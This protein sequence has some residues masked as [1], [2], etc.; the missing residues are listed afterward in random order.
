MLRLDQ[1]I[2]HALDDP[3]AH[4]QR[5]TVVDAVLPGAGGQDVIHQ[6]DGNAVEDARDQVVRPWGACGVAVHAQPLQPRDFRR[7]GP[8]GVE[9]THVFRL[10]R[11]G[12]GAGGAAPPPH[13][14]RRTNGADERQNQQEHENDC[15]ESGQVVPDADDQGRT[16]AAQGDREQEAQEQ[17]AKIAVTAAHTGD[18]GG[19]AARQGVVVHVTHAALAVTRPPFRGR[20]WPGRAPRTS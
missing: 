15:E 4:D 20:R 2:G 3:T 9:Q 10:L 18:R 19:V 12:H 7:A 1:E 6:Q 17:Q 16:D 11:H 5:L 13:R 8:V 14:Q